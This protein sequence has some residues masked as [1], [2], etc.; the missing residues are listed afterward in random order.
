MAHNSTE[1]LIQSDSST[2]TDEL[3]NGSHSQSKEKVSKKVFQK[4]KTA[5]VG[6]NSSVTSPS[7]SI[8]SSPKQHPIIVV[9]TVADVHQ[10]V[11]TPPK[12]FPRKQM[13]TPVDSNRKHFPKLDHVVEMSVSGDSESNNS[14][15]KTNTT[16]NREEI[17]LVEMKTQS[18]SS[19]DHSDRTEEPKMFFARS[20]KNTVVTN[21]DEL[22][23]K[24]SGRTDK[25][26]RSD[27][28]LHEEVKPMPKPRQHIQPQYEIVH[29]KTPK[30]Q[31]ADIPIKRS[32]SEEF[33]QSQQSQSIHSISETDSEI[34]DNEKIESVNDETKRK[35]ESRTNRKD[36]EKERCLGNSI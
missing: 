24:S 21:I 12:P 2:S 7:S 29:E 25:S 35:L 11:L 32:I 13:V 34:D 18:E 36:G 16:T 26:V 3:N 20:R 4:K 28:R 33:S 30:K 23:T 9:G 14:E 8:T 5:F 10:A 6:V 15:G 19:G 1:N 27:S 31:H 22:S 17:E